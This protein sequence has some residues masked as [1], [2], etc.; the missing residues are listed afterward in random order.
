MSHIFQNRKKNSFNFV[1]LEMTLFCGASDPETG[2]RLNVRKV[3][4]HKSQ[5]EL[6]NLSAVRLAL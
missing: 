2:K 6:I 5:R 3:P 4:E 1:P